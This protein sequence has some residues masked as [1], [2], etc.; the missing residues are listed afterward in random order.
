MLVEL[1][2]WCRVGDDVVADAFEALVGA[3]Y[4]EKGLQVASKF[5]L[6]IAEV[7]H[8]AYASMPAE[9]S[10]R[11]CASDAHSCLGI[12]AV[13]CMCS[14]SPALSTCCTIVCP[15]AYVR[16]PTDS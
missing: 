9:V 2:H 8:L 13:H 12:C 4:F 1:W 3:I 10:S 6:S 11:V 5:V 15:G 7:M 16:A 14:G